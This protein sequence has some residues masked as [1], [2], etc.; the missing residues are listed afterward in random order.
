MAGQTTNLTGEVVSLY[1]LTFSRGLV[2]YISER[3]FLGEKAEITAHVHWL[4]EA[5]GGERDELFLKHGACQDLE[6]SRIRRLER[7]WI[8]GDLGQEGEGTR[9]R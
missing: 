9:V 1:W 3:R 6:V 5:C 8:Q 4:T 7:V 2:R